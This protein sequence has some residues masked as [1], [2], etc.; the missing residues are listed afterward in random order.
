MIRDCSLCLRRPAPQRFEVTVDHQRAGLVRDED[1]VP[2][3]DRQGMALL[4]LTQISVAAGY[5][6]YGEARVEDGADCDSVDPEEVRRPIR[7]DRTGSRSARHQVLDLPSGVV[8]EVGGAG[9][10]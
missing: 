5:H 8:G 2:G 1:R 6:E 4:H 10:G 7:Q 9:G 3:A